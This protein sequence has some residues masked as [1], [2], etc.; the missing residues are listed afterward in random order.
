MLAENDLITQ[1]GCGLSA[2]DLAYTLVT[3]REHENKVEVLDIFMRVRVSSSSSPAASSTSSSEH[4]FFAPFRLFC[5]LKI[6]GL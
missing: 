1:D 3:Q 4:N 2:A 5:C 6:V